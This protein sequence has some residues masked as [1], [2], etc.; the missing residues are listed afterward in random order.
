VKYFSNVNSNGHCKYVV[1][2]SIGIHKARSES[3]DT[4]IEAAV[5]ADYLRAWLLATLPDGVAERF[6][7]LL[8][9]VSTP[10]DL[11]PASYF[12]L[13]DTIPKGGTWVEKTKAAPPWIARLIGQIFS[14]YQYDGTL[15][16]KESEDE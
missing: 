6:E 15:A 16:P 1:R 9:R 5:Q 3:Y 10:P 4:A 11:R 7:E 8:S 2:F 13:M 12:E 14:T